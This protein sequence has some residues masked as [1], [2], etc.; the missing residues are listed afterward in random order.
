MTMKR[1]TFFG[2]TGA[3]VVL[4]AGC[5]AAHENSATTESDVICTTDDPDGTGCTNT[6]K[7]PPLKDV[8]YLTTELRWPNMHVSFTTPKGYVVAY[9]NATGGGKTVSVPDKP[10]T[11]TRIHEI[12]VPVAACTDYTFTITWAGTSSPHYTGTFSTRHA[13]NSGIAA[14]FDPATFKAHVGFSTDAPGTFAFS[15]AKPDGFLRATGLTSAPSFDVDLSG[16]RATWEDSDAWTVKESTA[17][18]NCPVA[19]GTFDLGRSAQW[20]TLRST[21]RSMGAESGVLGP[22]LEYPSEGLVH[23]GAKAVF[24]NGALYTSPKGTYVVPNWVYA[25]YKWP[26]HYEVNDY[27]EVVIRSYGGG[28]GSYENTVLGLPIAAATNRCKGTVYQDFEGGR[29]VAYLDSSGTKVWLVTGE[30]P[31]TAYCPQDLKPPS[32]GDFDF[33]ELLGDILFASCGAGGG[34][35]TVGSN[36]SASCA[37]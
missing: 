34:N 33:F 25:A 35:V 10:A 20:Q 37:P 23:G 19:N 31:R 29:I 4:A 15:A 16:A 9:V 2:F 3:L 12:D 22:T 13:P 8:T 5:A 14:S 28:S 32:S 1:S 7:N 27:N 11:P 6:T 17:A 30:M 24:S 26:W 36:G 21:Y 18:G